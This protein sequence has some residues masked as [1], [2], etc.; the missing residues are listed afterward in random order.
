MTFVIVITVR[1]SARGLEGQ[2]ALRNGFRREVMVF[3]SVIVNVA[4]G[5]RKL[6]RKREER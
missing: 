3:Q 1:Q 6:K 2:F 4:E 5:Q